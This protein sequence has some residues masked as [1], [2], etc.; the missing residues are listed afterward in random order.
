[1]VHTVFSVDGSLYQRWQA[2]LLA[3]SHRKV[4]Q[5]GP[6]TRLWSSDRRPTDFAGLTFRATPYSRH[7]ISGDRYAPYNKPRAL[8]DWLWETPP[9]EDVLLLLDP[10]CVFL[11]PLTV[12]V[13]RGNPIAQSWS[14]LSGANQPVL[15]KRH[16]R[17]PGSVQGVGIPILIHRDD[18][19]P[20]AARWLEKT[21][22]IRNDPT[23]RDL[24]GWVAEMWGYIFA[25]AEIGLHHTI[26]ELAH[27]QTEDRVELP[28][29]HYCHSS[30]DK[31][32]RWQW[33]KRTYRPW[34]PVPNPPRTT[35]RTSVVL[36]GLL[37][38]Y[39]TTRANR[40][41]RRAGPRRSRGL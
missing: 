22:D 10:D 25:C 13:D 24:A 16:C 9:T 12:R 39:A 23:S 40:L 38:E 30:S 35:P 17:K 11:A 20:L 26:R 5:P 21:E 34:K 18:L 1:M 29:I 3:H 19:A 6:L 8:H 14:Q 36:I 28:I 7:P 37:N 2:D 31:S 4:G 33:D 27:F 32:G 15:V 41:L